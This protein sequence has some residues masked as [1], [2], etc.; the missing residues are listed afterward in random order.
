MEKRSA[1]CVL[2]LLT[3][4]KKVYHVTCFKAGSSRILRFFIV[5]SVTKCPNNRLPAKWLYRK[6]ENSSFIRE[7]YSHCLLEVLK[8]ICIDYLQK[9]E[10]ITGTHYS[11]IIEPFETRGARIGTQKA[12]LLQ[13]NW[14][15]HCIAVVVAK[16]YSKGS[17]S[18]DFLD[19]FLSK[20]LQYGWLEKN[21]ITQT[22]SH[23][24]GF[25]H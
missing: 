14:P 10:I 16:W 20:Y 5:V 1:R 11:F 17:N 12:L 21:V 13:D 19:S 23:Y 9:A 8:R 7:K 24:V 2:R 3:V 4:D 18:F 6:G 15:A 22:I 25:D